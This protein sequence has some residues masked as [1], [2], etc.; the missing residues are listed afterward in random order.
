M[1]GLKAIDYNVCFFMNRFHL[2][3]ELAKPRIL[4]MVLV[5]TTLGFFL[6]ERSVHPLPRFGT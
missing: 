3:L 5:T 4:S 6:G 2:Y 1:I